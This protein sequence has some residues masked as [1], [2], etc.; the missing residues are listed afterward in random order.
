MTFKIADGF[1]EVRGEVDKNSVRAS[2]DEIVKG[3]TDRVRGRR[4][5]LAAAGAMAGVRL[6]EEV[7]VG[8]VRSFAQGLSGL[9][10]AISSNP[11]VA[12]AGYGMAATMAAVAAPAIGA[13][14]SAAL[15]GG[16]GFAGVAAGIALIAD[17]PRVAAAGG[18]LK[19]KLLGQLKD[20]A[21]PFLEPTLRSIGLLDQ[22][23]DRIGPK[24]RGMFA[25]LAP[26]VEPFTRGLIGFIEGMLPGVEKLTAAFRPL[27]EVLG[28][29]DG[30]AKLGRALSQAFGAIAGSGPEAAVFLQDFIN[31]LAGVI[32]GVGAV[33][34]WLTKAYVAVR[35]FFISI[36]GWLSAA[37][38]WFV[39]V[40]GTISGFFSDLWAEVSSWPGR[41]G[42]SLAS[43]G[44]AIGAWVGSVV[45]WFSAL[46]GRIWGFVQ[47]LPAMLGGLFTSAL[48]AVGF[49]VGY[50]IGLAVGF[51]IALPGRIM[52]AIQ[53]I[54]GLLLGLFTTAMDN[55]RNV[56]TSGVTAVVGFFQALPGR[57][58]SAVSSLWGAISGAFNSALSNARNLATNLVNTVG[59]TLAAL[60]GRAASAVAG[61]A[62]AI[63]GAL[64]S[65]VGTARSIGGDIM[66]GLADGIRAA[67][68]RAISAAV[69]AMKSVLAGAKAALG[70]GSPSKEFRDQVGRW[71]PPGV[72]EGVE[73]AMPAARR[74]VA[75]AAGSLVGAPAGGV[76]T[77]TAGP[78]YHFAAGSIVLDASKVRSLQDVIDL[79]DGLKTTARAYGARTV[80]AGGR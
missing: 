49:A 54:P 14:L 67:V 9:Q 63:G 59:S 10:G 8:T 39:S 58:A 38:A 50:G 31:W 46:P 13:L 30:L 35:T 28:G 80:L 55:A 47:G 7:A 37:G 5:N 27:A 52:A 36:P 21:K 77:T 42:A 75:D 19:D 56:V 12:A 15:I 20:A 68:G 61:V 73:R 44:S 62:S 51:F 60:P 45:A 24:F 70:I 25:N 64:S 22:A 1:V 66:S 69:S 16:V 40:W 72:T 32:I 34:A 18:K 76:G 23:V 78:T 11:Y 29:H 74:S 4:G 43:I 65:A 6:G 26:T 17:D 57:A 41:L 3:I 79:V 48:T 53:A 71:I 2:A 33:V